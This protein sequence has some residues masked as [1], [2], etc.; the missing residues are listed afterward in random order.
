MAIRRAFMVL[1]SYMYILYISK[2]N[3]LPIITEKIIIQRSY[4]SAFSLPSLLCNLSTDFEKD[5][6]HVRHHSSPMERPLRQ[7]DLPAS[8]ALDHPKRHHPRGLRFWASGMLHS[9]IQGAD[10]NPMA[11]HLLALQPYARRA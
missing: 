2:F 6:P 5:T 11:A 9:C 4:A 1:I 8:P 10:S 3:N 7:I